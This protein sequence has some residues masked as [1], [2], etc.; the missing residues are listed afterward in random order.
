MRRTN[1]REGAFQDNVV[2]ERSRRPTIVVDFN[3]PATDATYCSILSV[4]L[5][6]T[7]RDRR[8]D[9]AFLP[10]VPPLHMPWKLPSFHRP[11]RAL[12]AD[13]VPRDRPGWVSTPASRLV[14]RAS[15][16]YGRYVFD[17]GTTCAFC[18]L[19]I[20]PR[21]TFFFVCLVLLKGQ[22]EREGTQQR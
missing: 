7:V 14:S 19:G 17:G 13:R 5:V 15:A 18:H 4:Y 16:A 10:L 22:R 2:S 12:R 11:S 6:T 1:G 3:M 20:P 21:V 8:A 9:R